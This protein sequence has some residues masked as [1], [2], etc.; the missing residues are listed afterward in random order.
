VNSFTDDSPPIP[1]N[2]DA[3]GLPPAQKG[4]NDMRF[5]YVLLAIIQFSFAFHA[6]RTGRGGMWVTIIIVFPVV[7]CLAYYFME[8]FPQSRE[9]RAVRKQ[10]RDIAKALNPDGELKRRTEEASQNASVDNRAKLADECLERG[11]FDEA[12]RLY[13]G[14]L[15][16]P[17]AN[18]PA[19][20][21]SCARARFY[22]GEARQAEEILA[23]IV[24][25]HPQYRADEVQ[26]LHAR[27]LQD[28]GETQRA[29]DAFAQLKDRYVGFEAKY[30]YALLLESVGRGREAQ[31]LY[32]FIVANARRSALESEQ[33]WV[34]S[35][36]RAQEKVAA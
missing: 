8:V 26:L 7:G 28:L 4:K 9:H 3:D 21:F 6:V 34:K 27:A 19:I 35:A 11:M 32:G 25:S 5:L 18:D 14:C 1:E 24:R 12:I 22:N 10:V 15:E 2:L 30:R 29:L 23:R 36:R 31:E 16:G 33:Q 13:E 17:Y 20:L